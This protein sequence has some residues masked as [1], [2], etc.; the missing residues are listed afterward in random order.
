MKMP[1]LN[2]LFICAGLLLAVVSA[3]EAKE[4][5]AAKAEAELIARED[6]EAKRLSIESKSPLVSF[7]ARGRVNFYPPDA[8]ERKNNSCGIFASDKGTYIF[9]VANPEIL[10]RVEAYDRK[11]VTLIGK[12]RGDGK[13][14]IVEGIG[15]GGAPPVAKSNKKRI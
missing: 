3:A 1:E 6:D 11:E 14:F 12:L 4:D 15:G 13:Y 10:K 2:R 8:P 5:P 7:D 9:K